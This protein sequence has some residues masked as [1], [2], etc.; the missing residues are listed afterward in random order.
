MGKDATLELGKSLTVWAESDSTKYKNRIES[1]IIDPNKPIIN[2]NTE[3]LEIDALTSATSKYFAERGLMYTYQ[4]GRRYDTTHLHL[5]EWLDSIRVGGIPSCN[6]EKGF[7]EAITAH[8]ATASYQLGA[9]V[10]WDK[11]KEKI[12]VNR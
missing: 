4:D 10:Y 12:F 5:A 1:G 6:I 11:T 8:M 7:Q 3:N 9:K 2:Y